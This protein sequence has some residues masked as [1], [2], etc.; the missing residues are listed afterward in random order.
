[1]SIRNIHCVYD[2]LPKNVY[3]VVKAWTGGENRDSHEYEA[4]A[5]YDYRRGGGQHFQRGEKAVYSL[6]RRSASTYKK[7]EA[8][9]GT[10]LFER[11]NP[12]K[13]TPAG[14]VY[15]EKA[16]AFSREES[17][18]ENHQRYKGF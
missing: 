13:L 3:S 10:E 4:A 17:D 6:S 2:I 14:Q 1:M 15:I 7:L 16:G 12:L 9:L 11:T 18:G 5:V 8:E